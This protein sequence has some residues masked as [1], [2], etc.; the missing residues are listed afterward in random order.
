VDRKRKRLKQWGTVLVPAGAELVV[1]NAS[2]D[3]AVVLLVTAPPPAI[4][5]RDSE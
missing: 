2:Y 1:T 5:S 3:P 4:S